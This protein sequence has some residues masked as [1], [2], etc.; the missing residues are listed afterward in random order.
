MSR[1]WVAIHDETNEESPEYQSEEEALAWVQQYHDELA[2]Y[3]GDEWDPEFDTPWTIVE[4]EPK[5]G[6]SP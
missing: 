6:I 2:F 4:R 1:I 3:E 5:A